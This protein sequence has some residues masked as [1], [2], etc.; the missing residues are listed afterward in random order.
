MDRW[1]TRSASV[2]ILKR[3]LCEAGC[4]AAPPDFNWIAKALRAM[5]CPSSSMKVAIFA[6]MMCRSLST[7][8][9]AAA[10]SL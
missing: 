7:L 8:T 9:P 5:N 2:R 4:W 1:P 10:L 6:E 3:A